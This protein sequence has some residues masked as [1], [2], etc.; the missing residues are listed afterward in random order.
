MRQSA[1]VLLVQRFLQCVGE[2]ADA[3]TAVRVERLLPLPSGPW[4]HLGR[5]ADYVREV[6][7]SHLVQIHE[8][9][10]SRTGQESTARFLSP[11]ALTE[12]PLT[13]V[14]EGDAITV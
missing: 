1:P 14:P 7:P 2:D 5:A 12:V 11:E 13:I 9:M 10:L 6:A 3:L 8:I 4:T